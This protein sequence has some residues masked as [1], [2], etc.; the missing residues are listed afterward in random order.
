MG[1][2]HGEPLVKLHV[3]RVTDVRREPLNRM[4][5]DSAYGLHEARL[6]GF[7][8]LSGYGFVCMFTK[9]NGCLYSDEI[10]RIVFEYVD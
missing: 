10:T 3:I 7:P 9:A 6:E 5:E 8:E 1:R 2:K 4:I